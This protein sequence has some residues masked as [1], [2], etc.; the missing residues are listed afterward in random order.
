MDLLLRETSGY[1]ERNGFRFLK[2]NKKLLKTREQI[3]GQLF[4]G[5]IGEGFIGNKK[6]KFG[7]NNG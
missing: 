4:T 6:W 2:G 7:R 5:Y 1:T 3:A